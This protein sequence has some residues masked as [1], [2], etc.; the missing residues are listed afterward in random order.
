MKLVFRMISSKRIV[1]PGITAFPGKLYGKVLKTGKNEIRFSP[2]PTFTNPKKK[3]KYK[4][5][6]SRWKK[7]FK[8][9]GF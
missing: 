5:S 1:F 3:K 2:E 9:C 8:V 4:S 6:L 7:V